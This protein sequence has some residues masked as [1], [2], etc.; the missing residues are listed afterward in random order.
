[1]YFK[2]KVG[3]LD[4]FISGHTVQFENIGANQNSSIFLKNHNGEEIQCPTICE[5]T[6]KLRPFRKA[7][8]TFESLWLKQLPPDFD[9]A[10]LPDEVRSKFEK[11]A[12]IENYEFPLSKLPSSV[13]DLVDQAY[14]ELVKFINQV[15]GTVCWRH[16]QKAPIYSYK[17]DRMMWSMDGKDWRMAPVDFVL[18][19]YRPAY[20]HQN[21]VIDTVNSINNDQ[22][23]PLGHEL[24]REAWIQKD[25]NPRSSLVIGVSALETGV[26]DLIIYLVPEADWLIKNLSS[27]PIYRII[28]EYLPN[29]PVKLK[30]NDKVVRPSDAIVETIRNWSNKRN[31]LV[32]GK[33]QEIKAIELKEFLLL[34]G[35]I[36]YLCDFYRGFDWA[37]E[38][39]S[40][41]TRAKLTAE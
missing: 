23:E 33:E 20:L 11:T 19:D 30:V 41:D 26:K 12:Q 5:A 24:F 15:V 36:L 2:L 37:Y 7:L 28:K 6:I 21:F 35:D 39:I 16:A 32:H 17:V 34:V 1:M 8:P 25:T 29:L 13:Q 14:K 38:H 3:I 27:P 9:I 18:S 4:L 10:D 40:P 22:T 31:N